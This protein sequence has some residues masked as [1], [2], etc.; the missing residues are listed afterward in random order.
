M[1]LC[2]LNPPSL[3]LC[4]E[5]IQ[6]NK[7]LVQIAKISKCFLHCFPFALH[8][9]YQFLVQLFCC[10]VLLW[11]L[12]GF[13]F[14]YKMQE[15]DILIWVMSKNHTFVLVYCVTKP[16]SKILIA[17]HAVLLWAQIVNNLLQV[18]RVDLVVPKFTDKVHNRY[19][20]VIIPVKI[21]KCLSDWHPLLFKLA[22]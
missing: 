16:L 6:A 2:Y 4:F 8:L 7:S 19:L 17:K 9:L 20:P 12:L 15:I 18:V 11:Q 13:L 5:F 1:L 10:L 3:H 21:Q 22:S 14:A